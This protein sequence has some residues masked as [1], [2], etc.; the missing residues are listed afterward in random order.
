MTIKQATLRAAAIL[1]LLAGSASSMPAG[2]VRV[3]NQT[4]RAI[5][6]AVYYFESGAKS[7]SLLK[8]ETIPAESS[9]DYSETL[10]FSPNTRMARA[11]SLEN[12]AGAQ[13]AYFR[14][15]WTK[16]DGADVLE[17]TSISDSNSSDDYMAVRDDHDSTETVLVIRLME[18]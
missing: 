15:Q 18:E 11:F 16:R 5:Q 7:N 13:Y 17:L 6:V 14:V 12:T 9:W 8:R 1:A 3:V 4:S 10:R 2:V